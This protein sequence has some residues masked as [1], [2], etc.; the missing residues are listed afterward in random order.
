MLIRYAPKIEHLKCVMLT[1]KE[2][3]KLDRSM[4]QL[5]PG[6]NEVTDDEYKAMRG[7]IQAELDSGEIKI[8]AQKL[9]NGTKAKNL[10]EMSA[11]NAIRLVNECNSP[12]TLKKWWKEITK[13]EVRLAITKKMEKL[14]VE[15]PE[16]EIP[17]DD[18]T[19]ETVSAEDDVEDDKELKDSKKTADD[20]E[21]SED[22][23]DELD[24]AELATKTVDE[25]KAL[26]EKKGIDTKKLT[27]KSDLVE[28]LMGAKD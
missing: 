4:V 28:A 8:L 3:L 13:E 9:D 1:Q 26:C 22:E 19:S 10:K 6:T 18:G 24:E 12:D 11:A 23:D 25:L 2:G 21:G 17:D 20:S 7:N 27:K 16:D 14:G 5:I 15:P